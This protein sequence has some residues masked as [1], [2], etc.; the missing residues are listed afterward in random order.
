MEEHAKE[1]ER[2]EALLRDRGH[3]VQ[4][5]EAEVARRDRLVRELIATNVPLEPTDVPL[6]NGAEAAD[7]AA[8]LDQLA[9]EAA[10]READL[11]A[12]SW[13]ISQLE[14]ELTHQR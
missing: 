14:R 13:K 11:V 1:I 12:A 8:Q 9:S 7:L 10:R 2:F 5:L 3:Q 4:E 6:S